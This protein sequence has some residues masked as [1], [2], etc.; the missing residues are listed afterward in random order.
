MTIA[1][2]LKNVFTKKNTPYVL[3][4]A[5]ICLLIGFGIC[6]L[7]MDITIKNDI[8]TIALASLY[9]YWHIANDNYC[10]IDEDS[11][12]YITM[13]PNGLVVDGVIKFKSIEPSRKSKLDGKYKFDIILEKQDL[14]LKADKLTIDLNYVIGEC[15]ITANGKV[16]DTMIKECEMSIQHH[17]A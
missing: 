11:M 14:L 8:E 13:N 9:G 5:V 6:F 15:I 10:L 7:Y 4:I 12:T 2:D 3:G 16:V 1:E 17:S